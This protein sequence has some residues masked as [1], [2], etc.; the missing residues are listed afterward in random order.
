MSK[1]LTESDQR[2]IVKLSKKAKKDLGIDPLTTAICLSLVQGNGTPLRLQ[3]M[4]DSE[5]GNINFAHDIAGIINNLDHD[6]GQLLNCFCPRF[7][8]N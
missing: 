8:Q 4:L 2:L 7:S 6:T 3:E 5:P 1:S